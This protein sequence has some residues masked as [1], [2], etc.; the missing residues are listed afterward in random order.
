MILTHRPLQ[1]PWGHPVTEARRSRY[2]FKAPWSATLDLLDRELW[3]LDATAVVLQVDVT[4]ADLRLDGQLRANA[5]PDFPGVRLV[6]DTPRGTLSWQTDVC[7]FWQHNVRSIALG[8]EVLRAVDRYGITT[9]GEQYK[10]WLQLEAG[11][12]PNSMD[13]AAEVIWRWS[14]ITPNGSLPD[15]MIYRAA[16][17]NAHPDRQGGDRGPWD[18]VQAAG[19]LLG[20]AG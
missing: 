14:G 1:M 9:A 17:A 12:G 7:E 13:A 2:I 20:L 3:H 15:S 6:V 19:K 16:R 5:R 8:L 11:G 10:G 4:E 18:A